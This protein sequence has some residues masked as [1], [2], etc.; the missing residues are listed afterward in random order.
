VLPSNATQAIELRIDRIE[1]LFD[2]LDPFPFQERDLDADAEQYILTRARTLNRDLPM[3]VVIHLPAAEA[4]EQRR[5]EIASAF[6]NFFRF[7]ADTTQG[8][9]R[10]LLRVG[11]RAL[12]IGIAV[13][14]ACL[15][16]AEAAAQSLSPFAKIL[17]QSILILGWV[18]NWRPLEIFLYDWWPI[19]ARCNLYRQLA[20]A[21]VELRA[22]PGQQPAAP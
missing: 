13:L 21:T 7:R 19:R 3:R 5:Q 4:N 12:L 17:Q 10:E 15:L 16:V 8:E 9:L 14:A 20:A 2:T 18:A 22:L 1:Q 6:D 11:R